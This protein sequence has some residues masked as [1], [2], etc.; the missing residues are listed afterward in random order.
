MI[1]FLKQKIR[2]LEQLDKELILNDYERG[3][4]D[5]CKE[6]LVQA[7]KEPVFLIDNK[8]INSDGYLGIVR[9]IRKDST[10][11]YIPKKQRE[12]TWYNSELRLA[13]QQEIEEQGE[14][15]K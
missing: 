5:T 3:C 2:E 10:I 13:S 4:L 9:G 15:E 14:K 8:V 1:S 11:I 12:E 7:E 6:I